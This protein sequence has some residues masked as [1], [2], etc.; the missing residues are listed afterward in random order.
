MEETV[1]SIVSGGANSFA[2]PLSVDEKANS[3]IEALERLT[4]A[5]TPEQLEQAKAILDLLGKG[6]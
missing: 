4:S 6:E 2:Y 3:D 1:S 5:A